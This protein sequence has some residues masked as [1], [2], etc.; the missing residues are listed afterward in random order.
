MINLSRLL[1]ILLCP[2]VFT[3]LNAQSNTEKELF[4]H[5]DAV[6]GIENTGLYNGVAYNEFHK[7]DREQ[8]KFLFSN[9][10]HE[11]EITYNGQTYF[12]IPLKY[13]IYDDVVLV[14]LQHDLLTH[15][16]QLITEK[17]GGFKVK[18]S[19]FIRINKQNENGEIDGI[20]EVLWS[21]ENHRLVLLKKH[22][23]KENVKLNRGE[24]SVYTYKKDDSEFVI[25][26]DEKLFS[27]KTRDD[28]QELF[29]KYK[30][31]ISQ[32][33]KNQRSLRRSNPEKFL[34]NLMSFLITKI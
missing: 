11:G 34:T 31:D 28:F 24:V 1:F 29:P 27:V 10:M 14:K 17:I 22:R 23:L 20:Y 13:N 19:E 6:I 25:K 8:H 3:C 12:N 32:F 26:R 16:F 21:N 2:T 15:T 33:Y 18:N 7:I 9:E 30:K 4:N 5:F